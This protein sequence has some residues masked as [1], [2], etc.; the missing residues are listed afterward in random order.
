MEGMTVGGYQQLAKRAS[1]STVLRSTKSKNSGIP[2]KIGEQ[3][4][5]MGAANIW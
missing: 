2:N 4:V 1:H 3:E 5:G